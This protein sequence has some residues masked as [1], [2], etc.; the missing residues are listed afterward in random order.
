MLII[1]PFAYFDPGHEQVQEVG[2][3]GVAEPGWALKV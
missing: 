1:C 2:R 3:Q